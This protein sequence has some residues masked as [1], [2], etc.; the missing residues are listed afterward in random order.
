[1]VAFEQEVEACT[2]FQFGENWRAF[3]ETLDE[4]RICQAEASLKAMLGMETLEGQ[5]FLDIGCGSGLFSLAARRLG[6]SVRSF[7]YDPD[8]V[9]CARIL[10]QRF[11]PNDEAWQIGSGS[12]LEEDFMSGL[13]EYDIV[14]SWG[15]LHHTGDMWK[16]LSQA[17][18]P[19]KSQGKLFISIY[20][21]EGI[22]SV[23][24]LKI[25]QAY[26]RGG[27]RRALV[28]AACL[29]YFTLQT[30]LAGVIRS[31]NPVSRFVQYKKER[32]MSVYHDWIDWL[33]GLPFE[34]AKV[35]EVFDFYSEKGF[36]IERIKTTNR[37]GTNEF[38]FVN[39]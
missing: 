36:K 38:V 6:A 16:A 25:K 34:V 19:V 12:V 32:G 33:G 11:F 1:M 29:P 22:M 4:E 10:R 17:A 39:K 28:L 37:L 15:V 27:W 14:Y 18:I 23:A 21:D 26:N 35:E 3:L 20:N 30:A 8:S 13:G 2:R 7:D 31:G 5:K 9:E 24:W